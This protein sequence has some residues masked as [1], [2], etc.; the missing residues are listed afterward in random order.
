MK[1]V[2]PAT[3]TLINML[4]HPSL[5]HE[6]AA[7]HALF[8]ELGSGTGLVGLAAA[9]VG[10]HVIITDVPSV[11]TYSLRPNVRANSTCSLAEAFDGEPP[12]P[13]ATHIGRFL[14]TPNFLITINFPKRERLF[15]CPGLDRAPG[16]PARHP[17]PLCSTPALQRT[18]HYSSFGMPVV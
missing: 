1:R 16:L 11:V 15:C 13:N 5:I 6:R 9:A 14:F 4:S 2:W 12:F 8:L 3:W 18:S 17:F 10:A 7:S